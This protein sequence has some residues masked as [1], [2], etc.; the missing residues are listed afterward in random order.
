MHLSPTSSDT[1][2]YAKRAGVA[3]AVHLERLGVLGPHLLLGHGVWLDD[4]E[5]DAILR[6]DTAIAYCP[7]AYLRLAQGVCGRSR[8]ADI[9]RRHG[10]IAL[11]CDASN[12][13]DMVDVLRAGALAAGI[14]RDTALDPGA[15]TA[16]DVL[17]WATIEGAR[18]IGMADRIGSIEVG[19]LADLVIHHPQHDLWLE[20]ADPAL[21]LVWGSDGRNVRDVIVGGEFVVRD[22]RCTRIDEDHLRREASSASRALLARAGLTAPIKWPVVDY[23]DGRNDSPK[24]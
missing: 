2:A 4:D 21:T 3:P 23:R 24:E 22:R 20:H 11:G 6:T 5:V 7:W 8:H 18:A 10:R 16:H 1:E 14:A 12:A 17:E 9:F 15:L 13:S 19:K